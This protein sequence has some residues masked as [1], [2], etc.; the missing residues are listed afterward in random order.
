MSF[1]R[2]IKTP[3]QVR[4][5]VADV[6]ERSGVLSSLSMS[7]CAGLFLFELKIQSKQSTKLGDVLF[8]RLKCQPSIIMQSI[9]SFQ[10]GQFITWLLNALN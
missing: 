3:T 2:Y 10:E 7:A 8:V 9:Q 1:A 4:K 6:D 5:V